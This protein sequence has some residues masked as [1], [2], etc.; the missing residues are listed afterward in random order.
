MENFELIKEGATSFYAPLGSSQGKGPVTEPVFF[1]PVGRMA[2]DIFIICLSAFSELVGSRDLSFAEAFTGTGVK[3]IRLAMEGN[4]Y[5]KFFMNDLNDAAVNV[6]GNNARLNGIEGKVVISG[7][8]VYSFLQS[9]RDMGGVDALDIDPFG[10]PAPFIESAIRAT[11]NGGLV[12]FTATD[13]AVLSG[14]HAAAAEKKYG[15]K[16]FRGQC[17]RETSARALA[18]AVMISGARLDVATKPLFFHVYKHY[19]RGYFLA[20]RSAATA[21]SLVES[22]GHLSYCSCGYMTSEEAAICPQCFRPLKKAGPYY[23]GPLFDLDFLRR[24]S[25]FSARSFPRIRLFET[26]LNDIQLPPYFYRLP[27]ITDDMGIPTPAR[28]KV[29]SMLQKA[30]FLASEPSFDPQGIRTNAPFPIIKAIIEY[31]S[32]N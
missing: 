8:D 31:V 32:G 27:S 6:V 29:I 22:F 2:R 1:N 25:A 10:S 9:I 5:S 26:A 14:V 12:S 19:I 30:G 18:S 24:A 16:A 13:T 7:R 20:I 17:H 3:G 28:L 11:K 15:I 4:G 21:T 23:L